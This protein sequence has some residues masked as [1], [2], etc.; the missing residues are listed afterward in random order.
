MN[1]ILLLVLFTCSLL[2]YVHSQCSTDQDCASRLGVNSICIINYCR[3]KY[4]Y[5]STGS[6]C[7]PE[8][9]GTG[10]GN[11]QQELNTAKMDKNG[12]VWRHLAHQ[13][14]P[15][16]RDSRAERARSESAGVLVAVHSPKR[17]GLT[18]LGHCERPPTRVS[19]AERAGPESVGVHSAQVSSGN[20]KLQSLKPI[21]L[22]RPMLSKD[23]MSVHRLPFHWFRAH[24]KIKPFHNIHNS[25]HNNNSHFLMHRR[26][27]QRHIPLVELPF[28]P[29]NQS[30]KFIFGKLHNQF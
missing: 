14:R 7:V 27:M 9:R 13:E 10:E 6:S 30:F 22:T 3:C 4:G 18:T 24:F 16:T 23:D 15:P 26:V 25:S 19:R 11:N 8:G 21:A 12:E 2:H 1:P 28:K 20:L 29:F 17:R 5:T